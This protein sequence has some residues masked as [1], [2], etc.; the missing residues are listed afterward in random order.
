MTEQLTGDT[1]RDQRFEI[2]SL[3]PKPELGNRTQRGVQF[4]QATDEALKTIE[5]CDN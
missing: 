5:C 4:C 2:P 1:G 3:V